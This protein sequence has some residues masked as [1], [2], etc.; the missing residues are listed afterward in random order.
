M[1]AHRVERLGHAAGGDDVVVLDQ[2]GVRQ[3]HPVV[4]PAAAPHGVLLQRA[5]ARRRLAGVADAAPVPARRRPSGAVSGRDA[6][7]VAEQ[8]QRGALGGEQVAGTARSRSP[9]RR[10]ARPASPSR[11]DASATGRAPPETTSNTAAATG[12]ARRPRPAARARGRPCERWS[13]GHRRGRRDVDPAG[14]GPRRAVART[15][16]STATGS[17]PAVDEPAQCTACGRGSSRDPSCALR[18]FD[19]G[20]RPRRRAASRGRRRV[21]RPYRGGRASARRPGRGSPRASASRASPRARAALAV[22]DRAT[23]CRFVVSQASVCGSS[24]GSRPRAREHRAGRGQRAGRAQHAGALGHRRLQRAARRSAQQPR[25]VVVGRRARGAAAAR[26]ARC[27]RSARRRPAPRAASSRRA[28]SRRGPRCTRTRRRRTGPAPWCGRRGRCAR[29][30]TRSAQAGA[31]GT[32]RSRGRRRA[33]GTTRGSSGTAA[34]HISAPRLRPSSHTCS[35][36][37]LAHP[38]HDRLGHDVARARGRRA[39]AD[40]AMNA[41]AGVVDAGR[42]PR[43]APPR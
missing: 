6:G 43:R 33:R 12:H 7:E 17:S 34:R 10:R 41:L 5:Q 21:R 35:A 38:A 31:T 14:R 36:P 22:S 23:A 16:A 32:A 18:G 1:R 39:G 29:R 27:R 26:R 42:R 28:G 40:P 13:L 19:A 24:L 11:G 30:R 4:D 2:R 3:R 9:A 37:G 20:D 15:S 8:V 25:P